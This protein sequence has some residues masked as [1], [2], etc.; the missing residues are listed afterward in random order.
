LPGREDLG[1]V[2][3]ILHGFKPVRKGDETERTEV[4]LL[5]RAIAVKRR[6]HYR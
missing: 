2:D 1:I 4:F 3:T 6:S 5:E